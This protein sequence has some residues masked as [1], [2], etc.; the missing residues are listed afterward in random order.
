M[1]RTPL[2]VAAALLVIGGG[3]AEAASLRPTAS[4]RPPSP[5]RLLVTA[6]E[7][8]LVLSRPSL[9]TGR[10]IVELVNLGEDEHDLV[11]RRI[12]RGTTTRRIRT[13][14]P[15]G[16]DELETRLLPG[17]YALW[18]TLADHRS[19]GMRATLVVVRR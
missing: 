7:F 17:R 11:L 4:S 2:I 14:A 15:G 6:R 3:V 16:V 12:G 1:T 10:A 8:T 18:C 19:R 13:V 9:R 5:G